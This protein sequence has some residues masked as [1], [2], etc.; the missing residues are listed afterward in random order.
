MLTVTFLEETWTD[1]FSTVKSVWRAHIRGHI[2]IPCFLQYSPQDYLDC[3]VRQLRG[4]CL[5]LY[6]SKAS[7]FT[8][9]SI[10]SRAGISS[11]ISEKALC[12]VLRFL[13]RQKFQKGAESRFADNM[14]A[15]ICASDSE[16]FS[17]TLLNSIGFFEWPI[18]L[19][20]AISQSFICRPF[21]FLSS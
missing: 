14:I 5:D 19:H 6:C 7:N 10:K 13:L 21:E 20:W 15:K 18:C 9:V 17:V 3:F 11:R 2:T 4:D 1:S 12:C 8:K 16:F